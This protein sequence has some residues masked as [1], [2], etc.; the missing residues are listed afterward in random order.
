M[1]P[2][3]SILYLKIGE[4]HPGAGSVKPWLAEHGNS[5]YLYQGEAFSFLI[6]GYKKA[7]IRV[8]PWIEPP[9]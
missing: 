4:V 3:E 9:L 2:A 5:R 6:G 8:E 1:S 7:S